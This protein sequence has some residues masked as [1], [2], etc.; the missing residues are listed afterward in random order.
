MDQKVDAQ[1]MKMKV[2]SMAII[3]IDLLSVTCKQYKCTCQ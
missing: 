2:E 3:S 1:E